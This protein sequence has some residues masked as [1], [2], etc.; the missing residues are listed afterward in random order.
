MRW[1]G[2]ALLLGALTGCDAGGPGAVAAFSAAR[3]DW[4]TGFCALDEVGTLDG[5]SGTHAPAPSDTI[6]KLDVGRVGSIASSSGGIIAIYND[7]AARVMGMD[8]TGVFVEFGRAGSGPGEFSA[9]PVGTERDH[10]SVSGRSFLVFDR[11]R[12]LE[13]DLAGRPLHSVSIPGLHP[14]STVGLRS[15]S[16]AHYVGV[17][18]WTMR[19]PERRLHIYRWA[20][21]GLASVG[22][23]PLT[24]LARLPSGSW[25]WRRFIP[26]PFWDVAGDCAILS[27]GSSTELVVMHL[28]SGEMRSLAIHGHPHSDRELLRIQAAEQEA[29]LASTRELNLPYSEV[30][31]SDPRRWSDLRYGRDGSLW[32]WPSIR[33]DDPPVALRIPLNISVRDPH[34][35]E[36]AVVPMAFLPGGVPLTLAS[37][38][39]EGWSDAVVRW[40]PTP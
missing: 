7:M 32:L 3:G 40:S 29:V 2:F 19:S 14:M 26:M 38:W 20:E 17:M 31:F 4:V 5:A 39:G 21:G 23:I 15:T 22:G 25:T 34:V 8:E 10:I 1:L 35:V 13:F 6:L 28:Q 30:E 12:F 36:D 16:D 18:E 24:P 27:D 33:P 9:P 11:L 37:A